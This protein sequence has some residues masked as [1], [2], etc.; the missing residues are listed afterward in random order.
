MVLVRSSMLLGAMA[1]GLAGAESTPLL[2]DRPFVTEWL[3]GQGTFATCADWDSGECPLSCASVTVSG[4]A[5]ILSVD[6]AQLVSRAR[7]GAGGKI[8]ITNALSLDPAATEAGCCAA[9]VATG[10]YAET[11]T[12]CIVSTAYPTAF[13]T[14]WERRFLQAAQLS[15]KNIAPGDVRSSQRTKQVEVGALEQGLVV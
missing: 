4:A 13:A 12:A 15:S 6:S 14:D 3:G 8:K 5:S 7:I 2:S 11:A 9:L 1:V 10:H